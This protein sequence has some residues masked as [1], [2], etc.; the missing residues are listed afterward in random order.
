MIKAIVII[1]I[2]CIGIF[3]L[4]VIFGRLTMK[5]VGTLNINVKDNLMDRTFMELDTELDDICQYD[6]IVLKVKEWE[7]SQEK[8]SS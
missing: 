8:Q 6:K 4:G 3:L 5:T 2:A 1:C 7:Y